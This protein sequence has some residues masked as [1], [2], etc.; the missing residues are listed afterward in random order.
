[1]TRDRTVRNTPRLRLRR[2]ARLGVADDRARRI[3]RPARAIGLGQDHVLRLIAGFE[4]PDSGTIQIAGEA[5]AGQAA[6]RA[7]R[8]PGVPG[9]RA[10]SAHDRGGEHRLRLRV[11]VIAAVDRAPRRRHARP[12]PTRR[13]QHRQPRQLTGGQ[14]QRVA[15][16]RALSTGRRWCCWIEPLGALDPKMREELRT[17][18]KGLQRAWASRSFRHARP[19]RGDEPRGSHRRHQPGRIEQ[20][21]APRQLYDR[22][23]TISSRASSAAPTGRA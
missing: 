19:G 22:P 14:H 12:R 3:L 23:Q 10:V 6:I 17:E 16:A 15:L 8:R 20:L 18:L 2:C 7:Q 4:Q 13:F 1:M 5:S 9:L 21:D 11:R